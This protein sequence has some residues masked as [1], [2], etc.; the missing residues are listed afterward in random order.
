MVSNELYELLHNKRK[1]NTKRWWC[2]HKHKHT[3]ISP[4]LK[5]RKNKLKSIQHSPTQLGIEPFEWIHWIRTNIR[6]NNNNCNGTKKQKSSSVKRHF[7]FK[8]NIPFVS[9]VFSFRVVKQYKQILADAPWDRAR[10]RHR[11]N[12]ASAYSGKIKVEAIQMSKRFGLLCKFR[13][14]DAFSLIV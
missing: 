5:E 13:D 9:F 3:H 12:A 14:F 6:K 8:F 1:I 11:A 2:T 7:T 4:L 10:K